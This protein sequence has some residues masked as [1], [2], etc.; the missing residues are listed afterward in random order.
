MDRRIHPCR[1]IQNR[2]TKHSTE[3][4]DNTK[5]D[6]YI[7]PEVLKTKMEVKEESNEEKK[8]EIKQCPESVEDCSCLY[9]G[10]DTKT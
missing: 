1:R 5:K 4:Q 8:E 7:A 9:A 3:S 2:G 10:K 6:D